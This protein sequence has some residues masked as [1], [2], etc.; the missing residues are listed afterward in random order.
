MYTIPIDMKR[1]TQME[2]RVTCRHTKRHSGTKRL[3]PI[4]DSI[5][6]SAWTMRA[7]VVP[8]LP[9]YTWPIIPFA[10][11]E[12]LNCRQSRHNKDQT[13]RWE[14]KSGNGTKRDL[15]R[16]RPLVF[17]FTANEDVV[18]RRLDCIKTRSCKCGWRRSSRR[19]ER[20]MGAWC[21]HRTA[22]DR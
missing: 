3:L 14:G 9:I 13:D 6:S 5:S 4:S 7:D 10:T 2:R 17:L 19:V 22:R 11:G 20:A 18:W 21:W 8:P 16:A 15:L 1:S 12:R